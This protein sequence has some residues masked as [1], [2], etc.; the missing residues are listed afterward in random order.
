MLNHYDSI[1]IRSLLAEDKYLLV[2][3]NCVACCSL[4]N[5]IVQQEEERKMRSLAVIPP[6][7]LDSKQRQL[8]FY[9]KNGLLDD[10]MSDYKERQMCN[11]WSQTEKNIFRE[12]YLQHPKN[13]TFI[14]SFLE[15]KVIIVV[16]CKTKKR[17]L[18][19]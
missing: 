10:P 12:K 3:N 11:T 8:R 19:I 16:C 9:N 5:I 6:I 1:L 17:L 15:Q 7:M 14:A 2:L 4:G 18:T 13:F